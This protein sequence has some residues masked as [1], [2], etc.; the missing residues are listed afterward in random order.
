MAI[1]FHKWLF[2]C[3]F[4]FISML[5]GCLRKKML[6]FRLHENRF[7]RRLSMVSTCQLAFGAWLLLT[8][9]IL[10]STVNLLFCMKCHE[11]KCRLASFI[12]IEHQAHRV[13]NIYKWFYVL[14]IFSYGEREELNFYA[15]FPFLLLGLLRPFFSMCFLGKLGQSDD[16]IALSQMAP[17]MRRNDGIITRHFART[18]SK[19]AFSAKFINY[20]KQAVDERE[21]LL[22]PYFHGKLSHEPGV[23]DL[24][25]EYLLARVYWQWHSEKV[26]SRWRIGTQKAEI[27]ANCFSHFQ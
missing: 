22:C 4:L 25:G 27:K 7:A 8:R 26:L 16:F 19:G 21:H 2:R 24:A 23:S 10:L 20:D 1:C 12:H 9:H 3:R 18:A 13:I 11:A 6:F 14:G 5:Q 17:W 15:Y